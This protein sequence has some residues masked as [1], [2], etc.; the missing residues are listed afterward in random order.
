M[1][2]SSL[3][4]EKQ[5]CWIFCPGVHELR[6][7]GYAIFLSIVLIC[8]LASEFSLVLKQQDVSDVILRLNMRIF[9]K[10]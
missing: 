8:F 2:E 7:S 4:R 6:G 1:Y 10:K 9:F 5:I 3:V